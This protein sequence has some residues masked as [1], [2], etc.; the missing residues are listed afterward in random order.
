MKEYRTSLL[1]KKKTIFLLTLT[2]SLAE[3]SLSEGSYYDTLVF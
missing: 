1:A 3:N 2:T